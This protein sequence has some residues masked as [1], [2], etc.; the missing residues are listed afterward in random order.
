MTVEVLCCAVGSHFYGYRVRDVRAIARAEDMAPGRESDGRIGSVPL[1]GASVPVFSTAAFLGVRANAAGDVRGHVVVTGTGAGMRGWLVS[2]IVRRVTVDD[3]EIAV[4]PALIGSLARILFDGLV[5][6]D[7]R[8][9]LVLNTADS[10]QPGA[11]RTPEAGAAEPVSRRRGS[12]DRKTAPLL[13]T[14]SSPALRIPRHVLP[15][16]GV[17]QVLEVLRISDLVQVPLAPPTI[18]GVIRWRG[19]AVPVVDLM[20]ASSGV[21]YSRILIAQGR[22]ATYEPIVVGIPIH[23]DARLQRVGNDSAP[24]R[25]EGS[26]DI[27]HGV[28]T[29]GALQVGLVDIGALAGAVA[30][31]GAGITA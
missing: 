9:L 14:F 6:V 12:T 23:D 30:S 13:I 4:L 8:S 20:G 26:Q 19:L 16:I 22:S 11:I 10:E 25:V 28:F 21:M 31:R 18:R 3:S 1:A 27:V 5:T 2:R 17:K 24:V 29:V 7:G 15:A